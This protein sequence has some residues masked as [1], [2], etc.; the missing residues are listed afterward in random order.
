MS[1]Y[2]W[3]GKKQVELPRVVN[4]RPGALESIAWQIYWEKAEQMNE[5]FLEGRGKK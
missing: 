2:T 5:R 4:S 1:M 3:F